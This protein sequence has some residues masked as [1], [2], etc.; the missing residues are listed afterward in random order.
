MCRLWCLVASGFSFH[1]YVSSEWHNCDTRWHLMMKNSADLWVYASAVSNANA[2]G[3]LN[4]II[5][6]SNGTSIN[7]LNFVHLRTN[8]VNRLRWKQCLRSTIN[9]CVSFHSTLSSAQYKIYMMNKDADKE[10]VMTRKCERYYFY[11]IS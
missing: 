10:T 2:K 8:K 5:K 6:L 1:S 4:T 7:F 3:T 9:I 11:E